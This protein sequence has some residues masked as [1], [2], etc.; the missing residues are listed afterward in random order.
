MTATRAPPGAAAG[1]ERLL[2]RAEGEPPLRYLPALPSGCRKALPPPAPQPALLCPSLRPRPRPR[3]V[4]APSPSPSTPPTPLCHAGTPRQPLPLPLSPRAATSGG[5]GYSR[6]APPSSPT[7]P[8]SHRPRVSRPPPKP[9]RAPLESGVCARPPR[10]PSSDGRRIP[11]PRRS[12]PPAAPLPCTQP[13]ALPPRANDPAA[14]AALWKAKAARSFRGP[15]PPTEHRRQHGRLR[16]PHPRGH[17]GTNSLRYGPAL[18]GAAPRPG[19]R[20][21]PRGRP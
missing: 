2:P 1:W 14:A 11:S 12:L 18:T 21:S 17:P 13:T 3:A 9:L 4:P 5:G 19:C 20:R 8:G 7:P 6:S 15:S 16:P 10:S